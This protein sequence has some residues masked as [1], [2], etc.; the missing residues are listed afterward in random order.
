MYKFKRSAPPLFTILACLLSSR[1]LLA[2]IKSLP[3]PQSHTASQPQ[4]QASAW[5]WFDPAASSVPVIGGRGWDMGHEGSS[6]DLYGRLPLR[7]EKTLRPA[8]WQLSRNCAGEY[9][10]LKT[11]AT[12][13]IVRYKVANSTFALPH[14]PATGVS[15]LDL[16]AITAKGEWRW[17]RGSFRFGDT[18]EYKF[19]NLSLSA[20]EEQFR[21]YLPLYNSISW[22]SIGVPAGAA[23]SVSPADKDAPIVLYGTSIMQGACASRPGLS[24]TNILGRKLGRRL[25]NLGF[26]G[27][28][29]LEQPVIDLM[30]ELDAKLFVLD[31]IPNL[32]E[33]D[34]FSQ[35]EVR[36]RI[37][38]SVKSLQ[39]RHPGTPILL[40]EHC[41]GL[42]GVNIDSAM[43]NKYAAASRLVASTFREM[44][45]EGIGNLFL[46]T[47]KDIGFD[48]ESTV[49][50]TH[51]NDMG[52][53]KYADA[54][55]SAIRKI[56]HEKSEQGR[57]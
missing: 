19:E 50:G 43:S 52:M 54:Y 34:R 25:I 18:I 37:V 55:A 53:M 35:E 17:A 51:P 15:G 48:G 4:T 22:M 27:N 20:K 24:W 56:L 45:M 2:Q 16:Y 26:S 39:S 42:N 9:I 41:C 14:M 10:T 33:R 11:S 57:K 13:I 47:D 31:C 40:T 21:L 49:D 30:N 46:L 1:L 3:L 44:K 5:Q 8:V 6:I 36:L 7:A 12:S 38:T 23:F 32:S 29:Q 28:G